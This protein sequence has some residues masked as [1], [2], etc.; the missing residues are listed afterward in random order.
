MRE[1]RPRRFSIVVIDDNPA[2]SE[3]LRVALAEAG[4]PVDIEVMPNGQAALEYLGVIE[5]KPP[6][7][8]RPHPCD[9]VLLD[10][11]LPCMNGFEVLE[12]LRAAEHLKMLPVVMMSGSSNNEEIDRSYRLGANSY[13]C[14]PPH[15]EEIFSTAARIVQYWF[16][17]VKLPSASV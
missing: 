2:D 13:I 6:S 15:L 11:N 14:K 3:M 1:V 7:G 12:R 10:L 4:A 17:C 16:G 5:G 9:L 8:S